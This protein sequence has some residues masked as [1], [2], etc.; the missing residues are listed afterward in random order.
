VTRPCEWCADEL[1]DQVHDPGSL[2]SAHAAEHDGVSEA[3]LDRMAE[4]EWLDT[5]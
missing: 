2:C 3:Q 1:T 5:L 4:A